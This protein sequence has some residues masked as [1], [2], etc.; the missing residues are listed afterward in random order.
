MLRFLCIIPII[1]FAQLY[2]RPQSLIE[3]I[4]TFL[5]YHHLTNCFVSEVDKNFIKHEMFKKW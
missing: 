3:R 2:I 1:V 4:M 5:E